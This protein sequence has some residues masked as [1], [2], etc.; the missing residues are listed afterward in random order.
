MSS[1]ESTDVP[2]IY[3]TE[4][5]YPSPEASEPIWATCRLN[6]DPDRE[7]FINNEAEESWILCES[8]MSDSVYR[9]PA[10]DET[11]DEIN[12]ALD[13]ALEVADID[14]NPPRVYIDPD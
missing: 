10:L 3:S 11:F 8:L 13:R 2:S 9:I 14:T 12:V 7:A 1:S 4:P 5:V 6:W